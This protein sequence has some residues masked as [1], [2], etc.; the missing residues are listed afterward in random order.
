MSNTMVNIIFVF[1]CLC[2]LVLVAWNVLYSKGK[3]SVKPQFKINEVVDYVTQKTPKSKLRLKSRLCYFL[4]LEDNH[5]SWTLITLAVILILALF[6]LYVLYGRAFEAKYGLPYIFD[7]RGGF[8]YFRNFSVPI[9]F[10][11]IIVFVFLGIDFSEEE[12]KKNE[13]KKEKANSKNNVI[14]FKKQVEK[15]N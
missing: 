14:K 8:Y 6:N 9:S 2:T 3:I 15:K 12:E 1:V 5:R 11:I 13:T 7:L 10:A 4:K